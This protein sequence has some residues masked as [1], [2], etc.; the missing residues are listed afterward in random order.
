MA[1]PLQENIDTKRVSEVVTVQHRSEAD[2]VS[3]MSNAIT[4]T[5]SSNRTTRAITIRGRP[6]ASRAMVF[7]RQVQACMDA[8][9]DGS[10][11]SWTISPATASQSISWRLT[12]ITLNIISFRCNIILNRETIISNYWSI[13]QLLRNFTRTGWVITDPKQLRRMKEIWDVCQKRN[14][15]QHQSGRYK[16]LHGNI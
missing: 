2:V 5:P 10:H 6:D 13:M 15:H 1:D 7:F 4:I 16:C 11:T 14:F 12:S 9:N 8:Y 3:M